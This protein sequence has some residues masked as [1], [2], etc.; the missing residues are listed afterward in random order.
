MTDTLQDKQVDDTKA[1]LTID[2]KGLDEVGDILD[3][4]TGDNQQDIDQTG[5]EDISGD[6]IPSDQMEAG[7]AAGLT[8]DAIYQLAESNPA[9]LKA[10]AEFRSRTIPKDEITGEED[11]TLPEAP[12]PLD[13]VKSEL[14]FKDD[15]VKQFFNQLMTN[16]NQLVDY[17]NKTN[18]TLHEN[19]IASIKNQKAN[20]E[21]FD[22]YV[23]KYFDTKTKDYSFIGLNDNLTGSQ[24]NAR[25]AIFNIAKT[26]PE[27]NWQERLDDAL[28]MW[29]ARMGKSSERAVAAN[30]DR[31]K[32]R[33]VPRPGG[34]K[35]QKDSRSA[36]QKALD[37][38]EKIADE[39]GYKWGE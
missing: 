32:K 33:F 37:D 6:L 25:Q 4:K 29:N 3:G 36:D 24:L 23:D 12:K 10:L 9:A 7:Y 30:L 39:H 27:G 18:Q 28:E 2:D 8:E 22:A 35:T 13:Y 16:H 26:L 21:E 17:V 1:E 11:E 19:Q 20:D 31:H 15:K 14:D 5:Q 38:F 34:Q